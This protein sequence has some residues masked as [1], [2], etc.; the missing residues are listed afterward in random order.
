M[1]ERLLFEGTRKRVL[2]VV[3]EDGSCPAEEFLQALSDQDLAKIMALLERIA[4]QGEIRNEEKCRAI[5]DFSGLFEF[6]GPQIRITWFHASGNRIILTHGFRKKS[7]RSRRSRREYE[8]AL[9]NREE[10]LKRGRTLQTEVSLLFTDRRGR[11]AEARRM[12]REAT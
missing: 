9:K 8:R 11:H 5:L 1:K 6:K 3:G 4:E 7:D 12:D 2:A 10:F